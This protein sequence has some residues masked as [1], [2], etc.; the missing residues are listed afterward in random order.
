MAAAFLQSHGVDLDAEMQRIQ[1][2]QESI[3]GNAE[4]PTPG[5]QVTSITTAS[6]PSTP[7][8]SLW[9]VHLDPSSRTIIS[10][11]PANA[12]SSSQ[13]VSSHQNPD[14]SAVPK[15][16]SSTPTAIN[17]H[18]A[19]L[20]PSLC[21]PHI[22]LDKAYLLSHPAYSHLR[23]DRGDFAEAMELTGKAKALFTPQDLLERGQRL[24]DESVAAGVTHMRA[25]VELDAGVGRKCLEAGL[26][27]KGKAEGE[28]RCRVQIC[29]FAQLPLFT[30]AADDPEG[31]VIR[32]LM[33]EAAAMEEVEALGG[34]PYVE[35]DEAKMLQMVDWLIDLAIEHKKHLDLHLDYNLDPNKEPWIWHII[36]TLR[37]KTWNQLNPNRTIVLGHCTRLTLFSPSSW[38]HLAATIQDSGLPISVVGLPTSD[39]FIMHQTLD[40]PR[41]IKEFN[42]S[43]CIGVNNIGNAFTPHGSCDPLT[44][45]CNGVGI[46]QAGTER[47]TE[48]LFEC[49]ST[50]AREAIGLGRQQARSKSEGAE[51]EGSLRLREGDEA[52]LLLFGHEKVAWRTRKT[53][54]EAVYFYDHCRGRRSFLD[55]K[56]VRTT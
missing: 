40:I 25:F 46:Y 9:N 56:E 43:A 23:M 51:V 13:D 32:G 1:F 42:L 21:H 17:A 34:V 31:A 15:K 41:M 47:D 27:L 18:G 19:L 39:L 38:H 55:G 16:D 29:A 5:N 49:V 8:G 20:T 52:S 11:L 35:G 48:V 45:A 4:R 50:R 33:E 44:L 2:S 37:A 28:G 22:H 54:A 3:Q 10:I 14:T 7:R 12:S 24:I 6:L 30:A 26:E 53:V 36:S